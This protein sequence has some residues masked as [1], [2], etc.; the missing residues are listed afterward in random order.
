M[1]IKLENI[2]C[3]MC[4]EE[5][6]QQV[7]QSNIIMGKPDLDLRPAG[8]KSSPAAGIQECPYC[9]YCNYDLTKYIDNTYKNAKAPLSLWLGNE[10]IQ[11]IIENET[12]DDARKCM[13]MAEQYMNISDYESTRKML[14]K[15][16]WCSSNQEMKEQYRS[17]FIEV[18]ETFLLENEIKKYI[19]LSDVSRQHS[20]FSKAQNYLETAKALYKNLP[21][22]TAI[23]SST[24]FDECFDFEQELID[25]KN[26]E[27]HN[28][29]EY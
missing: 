3:V 7:L 27:S 11:Y 13:I 8:S 19:Q 17:D 15:A 2:K 24:F 20:E 28:L 22:E 23:E 9:H 10:N 1:K 16:Y 29:S 5:S 26:V 6:E 4:K 25:E 14:I 18:F 21:I 12:D